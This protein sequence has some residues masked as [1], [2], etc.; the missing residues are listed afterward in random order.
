MYRRLKEKVPYPGYDE[1]TIEYDKDFEYPGFNNY[2]EEAFE[3]L[4]DYIRDMTQ[5]MHHNRIKHEVNN[6]YY[7]DLLEFSFPQNCS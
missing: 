1:K 6:R 2:L 5:L 3:T 7:S 4:S